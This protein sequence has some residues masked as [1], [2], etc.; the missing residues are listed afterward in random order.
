MGILTALIGSLA[1]R[2][3]RPVATVT[4]AQKRSRYDTFTS[5][6]VGQYAR[7]TELRRE[8]D[9]AVTVFLERVD[10]QPIAYRAGQ[11]LTFELNIDGQDLR[12]AYS[13]SSCP[14]DGRPCITVKRIEDGRVSTWVNE[15][16]SVGAELKVGRPS[17]EF[18][19][20]ESA[21]G[22]RH[23]VFIAGG[24]GIT[25]LMSLSR[26]ILGR[27]PGARI[28]LIYG[29]R[30]QQSI[31]FADSLEALA[32]ENERLTVHHVLEKKPPKFKGH[33]G[34]VNRKV[35]E[36]V[37]GEPGDKVF[38]LCGPAAMMESLVKA[39]KDMG[40]PS[41]RI[42]TERFVSLATPNKGEH[43]AVYPITFAESGRTVTPEPGQT[44]LE[45]GLDAG[46]A[47]EY[48]CTMGGCGACKVRVTKGTP[49]MDEPNCL[50]EEEK[51]DGYVLACVCYADSELEVE[52]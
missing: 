3:Q 43:T 48:S 26:D 4:N 52:A 16:L 21:V 32:A 41:E 45:A 13:F 35:L 51:K 36:S 47:L 20:D 19:V 5:R 46:I 24:S 10:G 2:K 39:L 14:T 18:V 25:P 15:R 12:R 29:N 28:D 9:D 23:Y 34:F 31:I 40:V 42:K 38:Y 33:K 11:F 30:D 27:E 6:D 49:V 17:G 37:V 7:V 8:T 50:L 44:L 1:G 22:D